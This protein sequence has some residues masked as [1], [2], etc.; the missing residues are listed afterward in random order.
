[1]Q[2][3]L[4]RLKKAYKENG[5]CLGIGA[6]A[7]VAS[8]IPGWK[9]LLK[10]MANKSFGD[11]QIFNYFEENG[12]SYEGFASFLKISKGE[13]DFIKILRDALYG[14]FSFYNQNIDKSNYSRFVK[15]IDKNSTLRAIAGFCAIEIEKSKFRAN[16]K[17]HGI[18]N[19]NLDNILRVY[20]Q[21]K[22]K[23]RFMRTVERASAGRG[24]GSI[25]TYH[26]H[27]MLRFD[28][29][30]GKSKESPDK[31]VLAEDEFYNV[32]NNPTEFYNYSFLYLLREYSFIFI[33]LSMQDINLRRLLQLSY[34][35]ILNGYKDEGV[36]GE[37]F[38]EK[39]SEKM[40]HFAL[41]E[42][43]NSEIL[44]EYHERTLAEMGVRIIWMSS[45]SEIPE[46]LSHV[47]ETKSDHWKRVYK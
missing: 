5:V 34:S 10:K 22:Y 2:K 17:V 8:N 35:E 41:L 24:E 19:F 4:E 18:I 32:F 12:L 14:E 23:K 15:E 38:L 9:G 39:K 3:N 21:A 36:K 1:M 26:I 42:R 45:Y 29:K 27:G 16:P 37:D 25:N 47:Y 46:I 40:K 6:G 20:A 11:D 30:T 33:G 44:V 28:R 43:P 13:S 31:L 7:S